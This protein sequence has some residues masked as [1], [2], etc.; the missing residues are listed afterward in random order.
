MDRVKRFLTNKDHLQYEY[1]EV[2]YKSGKYIIVFPQ[3]YH[4]KKLH[5]R[6]QIFPIP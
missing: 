6:L 1:T 5:W 4:Q 3:K 2:L